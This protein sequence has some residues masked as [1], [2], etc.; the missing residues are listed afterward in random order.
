[1]HCWKRYVTIGLSLLLLLFIQIPSF[2]EEDAPPILSDEPEP[3]DLILVP[4]SVSEP[5]SDP[6]AETDIPPVLA[7]PEPVIEYTPE[8]V[9]VVTPAPIIEGATPET[10][11]MTA[12][13]ECLRGE[14]T[15]ALETLYFRL[16][17]DENAELTLFCADF[18]ALI[19]VKDES[20]GFSE[21]FVPEQDE[22]DAYLPLEATIKVELGHSYLFAVSAVKKDITGSFSIDLRKVSASIVESAATEKKTDE[23]EP[24]VLNEIPEAVTVVTP[25]SLESD[26]PV[27]PNPE[28]SASPEISYRDDPDVMPY[29]GNVTVT[30]NLDL[31][32]IETPNPNLPV[33]PDA[34]SNIRAKAESYICY[35]VAALQSDHNYNNYTDERRRFVVPGA[36]YLYVTFSSNTYVENMYD[37]IYILT[38]SSSLVGTYTGSQLAGQTIYVPGDTVIIRLVT[39]GSISRYGYAVTRVTS[40]AYPANAIDVRTQPT[41]IT[42]GGSVNVEL[43]QYGGSPMQFYQWTVYN[44]SGQAVSQITN[45]NWK[46]TFQPSHTGTYAIVAVGYDGYSYSQAISSWFNVSSSEPTRI[47]VTLSGTS[48]IS[49]QTVTIITQQYSGNTIQMYRYIISDSNGNQIAVYDTNSNIFN[50]TTPSYPCTLIATVLAYDGST[51]V[52]ANSDWFSVSGYAVTPQISAYFWGTSFYYGDFITIGATQLAGNPIQ[53]YRFIISDSYGNTIAIYD[54]VESSISYQLPSYDC[55]LIATVLAYDG[56]YWC[57]A[58]SDW[59]SVL[60]PSVPF[61]VSLSGSSFSGGDQITISTTQYWGN[62]FSLYRYIIYDSNGTQVGLFDTTMSAIYY[63]APSYSCMLVV[64]VLAYDGMNW[65]SAYS[66]WFTVTGYTHRA[67]VIGN[68][69]TGTSSALTGPGNDSAAMVYMLNYMSASAYNIGRFTDLSAADIQ[70]KISYAFNGAQ[71]NDVSLFYYSGH[72]TSNGSLVGDDM[73]YVSPST[74]RSWLDQIPGKKIVIIDACHSGYMIGKDGSVTVAAEEDNLSDREIEARA[75]E[76][77]DA[78]MEGFSGGSRANLAASNYY[79]LCACA[80]NQLSWESRGFGYFTSALTEGCGWNERTSSWLSTLAADSN[81]DQQISLSE[82]YQYLRRY[83]DGSV[84]SG[85]QRYYYNVQAYPSGSSFVLFGR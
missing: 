37:K 83:Y 15:G 33:K 62:P 70:S 46:Y 17:A 44:S 40:N 52:S 85:G 32:D 38:G 81:Y 7:E 2:A 18:P 28:P 74:L 42:L 77:V 51:W 16:S 63:S 56:T 43:M 12:V 57:S 64:N 59:F 54:T 58:Y 47:G 75:A 8:P 5:S 21:T 14:I 10:A 61:D 68:T 84:V 22:Y 76:F 60:R 49:G 23:S 66:D 82:L 9:A 19:E 3:P 30:E 80:G 71:D 31:D 53:W 26:A 48:F 20:T 41:S 39:D 27:K 4:E 45:G 6:A 72:G 65:Y 36:S 69:Y 67:L 34:D 11:I 35:D 25:E 24:P 13:G 79:V 78:F 55:T 29:S 1:M 50:Y 73:R